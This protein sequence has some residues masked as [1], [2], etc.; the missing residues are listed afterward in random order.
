MSEKVSSL[1]IQK[2]SVGVGTN[3]HMIGKKCRE[4]NERSNLNQLESMAPDTFM[5]GLH[6]SWFAGQDS[7]CQN[8]S[9][10]SS[11]VFC[12]ICHEGEPSSG[13]KLISPCMC[14]GSVGLIHKSCVEKWLSIGNNDTCELCKCKYSVSRHHQPFKKWLCE[15]AVGDDQRNLVGDGICFV[16][17]TPLATLSAYLCAS[18]AVF[19][20]ENK[21]SEAVGLICLSSLLVII[22]AVWL[23]LSIRYHCQVWFKWRSDNPD[24]RLLNVSG[25]RPNTEFIRSRQNNG[26]QVRS[27]NILEL[28]QPDQLMANIAELSAETRVRNDDELSIIRNVENVDGDSLVAP[29]SCENESIKEIDSSTTS[30]ESCPSVNGYELDF[31]NLGPI[32]PMPPIVKSRSIKPAQCEDLTV[33]E[34]CEIYAQI[35]PSVL[36]R[37][38]HGDSSEHSKACTSFTQL[39]YDHQLSIQGRAVSVPYLPD[40]K[41]HFMT[42]KAKQNRDHSLQKSRGT[43]SPL[44]T[45]NAIF[46][47]TSAQSPFANHHEEIQVASPQEPSSISCKPTPPPLPPRMY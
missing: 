43:F 40:L 31:K 1:N 20:F 27:S 9:K 3:A 6:P 12:R 19:Y 11:G 7:P 37:E 25:S 46:T 24:I 5:L 21:T 47:V 22:Y 35:L 36:P 16:F 18:G 26:R 29:R 13:E 33:G 4:E 41:E 10:N 45:K 30:E 8:V 28:N 2:S 39:P 34:D 38:A 44:R 23:T 32:V 15:P 42:I 14:S 17:L